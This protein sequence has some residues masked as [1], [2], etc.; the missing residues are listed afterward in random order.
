[1]PDTKHPKSNNSGP[2][3]V[4]PQPHDMESMLQTLDQLFNRTQWNLTQYN[5]ATVRANL[6]NAKRWHMQNAKA[7]A[8]TK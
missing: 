7:N 2:F 3:C 8:R 1:M 6:K 4:N 5:P